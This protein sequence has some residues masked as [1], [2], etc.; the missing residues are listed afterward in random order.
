MERV[1][2]AAGKREPTS[3]LSVIT[4]KIGR[5][6]DGRDVLSLVTMYPGGNT[7]DG[8]SL[9]FDRGQFASQG[10][11]FVLPEDSPMLG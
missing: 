2:V 5:S 4:A 11:Y 8:H 9:P 3:V 7:I 6:Q 10:F 1:K